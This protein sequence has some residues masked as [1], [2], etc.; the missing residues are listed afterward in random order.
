MPF[1][2]LDGAIQMNMKKGFIISSVAVLIIA[3]LFSL[4][5]NTPAEIKETSQILI[6]AG[7]I[8]DC[9]R[10]T[11][12][13]TATLLEHFPSSTVFTTGDNVYPVGTRDTYSQCYEP[14]WG[15]VKARTR[16]SP[17]NHDYAQGT[18]SYFSYF[19]ENAGKKGEGYYSYDLGGWHIVMLDSECINGC[20]TTSSQYMWLKNDLETA[21]ASCTMAM[22]H[23][24]VF[25]S[26]MHGN[27]E[28]A[29][30]LW[31]LLYNYGAEV[32]VNGHDH[33][34]ERFAP[35][36]KAGQAD[37]QGIREFIVGTG[38]KDLYAVTSIQPN[39]EIR[40]AE[41]FGVMKFDLKPGSYTWEF[42]PIEGSTFTDKGEGSCFTR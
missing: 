4:K 12:E 40:N 13:K 20:N 24:P 3:F 42:I 29:H 9:S 31:N 23:H 10:D 33:Y 11:D 8:A 36:N 30:D 19:G 28:R 18:N 37:S 1:N 35:Q 26:G 38:G 15:K 5:T 2:I 34:Y 7:D 22:W 27:S 41:T 16:P 14:S 25:S 21:Q 17:G 6:G 39:S 32:V